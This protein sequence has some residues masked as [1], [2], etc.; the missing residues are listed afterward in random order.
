MPG[1]SCWSIWEKCLNLRR[2]RAEN[3]Y[4]SQAYFGRT[5]S[6]YRMTTAYVEVI[7]FAFVRSS[8]LVLNLP[9]T[10]PVEIG[11]WASANLLTPLKID[12]IAA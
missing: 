2:F 12:E 10:G 1:H 4:L 3:D 6:R 5:L 9:C 8:G 7:T 11:N